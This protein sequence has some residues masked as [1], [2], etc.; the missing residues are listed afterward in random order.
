MTPF[1]DSRRFRYGYEVKTPKATVK[2]KEQIRA[3][4]N[5]EEMWQL[6]PPFF[7][8]PKIAIRTET[9][10][11]KYKWV[12]QKSET[13]KI[14]LLPKPAKISRYAN[15]KEEM[16]LAIERE[17]FEQLLDTLDDYGGQYILPYQ[18]DCPVVTAKREGNAVVLSVHREQEGSL[19]DLDLGWYVVKESDSTET[20]CMELIERDGERQWRQT[21]NAPKVIRKIDMTEGE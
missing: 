21:M 2:Q 19:L 14:T 16:V 3:C 17:T 12:R 6:I 7:D 4:D 8:A 10:P 15:T 1:E 5:V 18:A 13:V 11:G 9:R 20:T